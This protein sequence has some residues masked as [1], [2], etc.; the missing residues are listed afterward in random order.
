MLEN[1]REFD[2][3]ELADVGDPKPKPESIR[4]SDNP[5]LTRRIERRRFV[6]LTKVNAAAEQLG[7]LPAPGETLHARMDGSFDGFDLIPAILALIAPEPIGR[8]KIATLSFNRR[9]GE[10]L[11]E[12]IDAEKVHVCDFL[13]SEMFAGKERAA[14]DW[15]GHEL[16]ARGSRLFFARN[17]C[18]LILARTPT[19]SIVVEGSQNLRTCRC[20]E[21]LVISDDREL[22]Y[23]HAGFI[24]SLA[25]DRDFKK[26]RLND[27][28]ANQPR[29]TRAPRRKLRK[30]RKDA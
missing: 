24:R 22:Y 10:R 23:F 12:L 4:L 16:E 6:E 21:Q 3:G 27:P 26:E 25:D 2:A 30:M 13:C 1:L 7:V 9:N 15:L 17:H 8:L 18:K 19:R 29:A 28:P 20:Y 14:V 5:T 11:L